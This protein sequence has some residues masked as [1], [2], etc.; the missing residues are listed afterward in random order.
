[1]DL[2]L[3]YQVVTE[4]KKTAARRFF[5]CPVEGGVASEASVKNQEVLKN[6]D[7]L[8]AL[9]RGASLF[10][11]HFFFCWAGFLS[12]AVFDKLMGEDIVLGW[13]FFGSW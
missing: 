7:T 1:M 11:T 6:E 12:N 3:E 4:Y 10:Y 5:C 2:R 8:P 13:I 9:L